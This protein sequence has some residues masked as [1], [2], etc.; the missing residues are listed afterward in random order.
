MNY[1]WMMNFSFNIIFFLSHFGGNKPCGLKF[2]SNK[3]YY[4]WSYVW[5]SS[6]TYFICTWS[7]TKYPAICTLNRAS[8]IFFI[9]WETSQRW[10]APSTMWVCCTKVTIS[11]LKTKFI[12]FHNVNVTWLLF[13]FLIFNF[14]TISLGIMNHSC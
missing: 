9:S 13:K 14:Y 7:F 2:K 1:C 12:I 5:K 11:Y 10:F 4:F 3:N 8:C 6:G